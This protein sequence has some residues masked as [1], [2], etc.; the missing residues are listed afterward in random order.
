MAGERRDGSERVS[1]VEVREGGREDV[2]SVGETE[3]MS[4]LLRF[5]HDGHRATR[6][7][8]VEGRQKSIQRD[9]L[10]FH[11]FTGGIEGGKKSA[12]RRLRDF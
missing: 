4:S 2:S 9:E 12:L 11:P 3:M 1:E 7:V 5:L 10:T 8:S 6:A